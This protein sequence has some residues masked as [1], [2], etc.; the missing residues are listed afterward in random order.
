MKL[1]KIRGGNKTDLKEKKYN[2]G[3]GISL[4]NKWFTVEN[5]IELIQ[6]SFNHTHD[7]VIVYVADSIHAI[8]LE[9]RNKISFEKASEIA[10]K[11]GEKILREVK[12]RVEEIFT[13]EEQ[14]R[15]YFARWKD[16]ENEDYRH[17]KD[18]VYSLYEKNSDFR[19][20]IHGIVK[21]FVSKE[22]RVFSDKDINRFGMYILEELPEVIC[23]VPAKG[24]IYEAYIYPFDSNMTK[25]AEDIQ[26]GIVF[27]EIKKNIMD[28]K[29]KVFLEVR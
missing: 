5:I 14:K 2:I 22:E 12:E 16:I 7:W 11:Q 13:P 4:G 3:I 1:Y 25:L 10:N 9:V 23:R 24:M 6:W 15:I 8:N 18:Y 26:L 27:P 20:Y 19:A 28:T 21:N 29:P 17:K